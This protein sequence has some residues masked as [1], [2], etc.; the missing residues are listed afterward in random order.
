M[1]TDAVEEQP[2]A[3]PE[4]VTARALQ[5]ASD[6]ALRYDI[7]SLRPLIESCRNFSK[8]QTLNVAVFGRFKAGKSSFLNC[9]IRRD[10][11]PVGVIPVT[12]VI[13]EI[14]YGP[15]EK[16]WVRFEGGAVEEI[17]LGQVSEYVDENLNP[18]NRKRVR[19]VTVELPSL[20]EFR[21]IRF[22]DTPG[23]E[24]VLSHNTDV[25]REWL[26]NVGLAIV[27][28]GVDPPLSQ[29]DIDLIRELNLYTPKITLLLT[30]A[31]LLDDRGLQQVTGYVRKQLDRYWDQTIPVYPYSILPGYEHLRREFEGALRQEAVARSSQHRRLILAR[32][33]DTLLGEC[34]GYLSV[35]LKAAEAADSDRRQVRQRILGDRQA[36]EDS[37]LALRLIVRHASMN[38][39]AGYEKML[40]PCEREIRA[41]LLQEFAGRWPAWSGSF[42][43]AVSAFEDWL[44]RSITAEI[45]RISNQRRPE[46]LEPLDRT[47]RQLSQSLQDFR[48]RISE[49][50][51]D[52]LGIE[53]RTTEVEIEPEIPRSPDIRIGRLFDREW[54]MISFLIPMPLVKGIVENHFRR[55]IAD[56]VF[57]N[58]SRLASQW[59]SRVNTALI[60]MEKEALRRLEDLVATLERLLTSAGEQAPLIRRDLEEAENLR[61]QIRQMT[62]D[63][64]ITLNAPVGSAT[65]PSRS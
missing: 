57:K 59:E 31:D 8:E 21:G 55:R 52:A 10:L 7:A 54:E 30:K 40:E 20:E 58:L 49:R 13:T 65:L 26:P 27:A 35:G 62:E 2:A 45:T 38:L 63:A 14:G 50:T 11:L 51:M 61:R 36:L 18:E 37:R 42:R 28:V 32:K 15:K 1:L 41:R 22:V 4:E 25:S 43:Q 9:L 47:G 48:N 53:L 29:R 3:A 64:T 17:P 60:Q 44:T 12:S 5:L 23:L 34:A 33:V 46:F 16:A 56:V 39:R 19:L 24:S 6:L